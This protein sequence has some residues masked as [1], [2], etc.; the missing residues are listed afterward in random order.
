MANVAGRGFKPWMAN[1]AGRGFKPWMANM[2][3]N[4]MLAIKHY[5]TGVY[6]TINESQK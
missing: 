1:M 3:Y 6:I 2:D 4:P 5:I